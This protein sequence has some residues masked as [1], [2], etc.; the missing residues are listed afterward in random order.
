MYEYAFSV[1]GEETF[2]ITHLIPR[3]TVIQPNC[4]IREAGIAG[5]TVLILEAAE[6]KMIDF[7][8]LHVSGYH[9]LYTLYVCNYHITR[10]SG[11]LIWYLG[12]L[13]ICKLLRKPDIISQSF[14][15]NQMLCS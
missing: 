12:K 14:M 1:W 9:N 15:L 10:C 2:L 5:D 4:T 8:R 13:G 11:I 6:N 7:T 3:G